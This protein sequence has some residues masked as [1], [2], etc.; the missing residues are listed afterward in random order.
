MKLSFIAVAFAA[1]SIGL[2]LSR[3][4][5]GALIYNLNFETDDD[6]VTPL[7][8][9]Q[10]VYS[11]PRSNHVNPG[12]PFSTDTRIEFGRLIKISSKNLGSD[13]NLGPAI[14]DS[15]PSDT[16]AAST[17]DPDLLVGLGNVLILQRDESPNTSLDPKYGL[18]FNN[19]NDEATSDDIGSIVIDFLLPNVH[20]MTIDL[21]D[22]DANL[23]LNVILTDQIGRNR[24]YAVPSNWTTDIAADGPTG[25][26][27]LNL[28]TLLNQSAAPNATGGAAKATQDLGFDSSRVVRLEVQ[29][30]G[31]SISGA[32]DNLVFSVPEPGTLWGGVFALG[33]AC[34]RRQ[35][36]SS[37]LTKITSS[38]AAR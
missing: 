22:V 3:T 29:F 7:V 33:I 13:G 26:K 11:T 30:L 10:S 2:S 18:K 16:L 31:S 4:T 1:V 32:I 34:W 9:G 19:P 24:T 17:Q 6:F 37:R 38:P 20:P 8:H 21:V 27:T 36:R 25:Y 15:D 23:N 35:G 12:V 28:Q 14:F 5:Q